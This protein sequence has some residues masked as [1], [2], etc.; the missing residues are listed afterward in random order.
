MH[1]L[2][3]LG[4]ITVS[5]FKQG[6]E[7]GSKKDRKGDL[8]RDRKKLMLLN[9]GPG[10]GNPKHSRLPLPAPSTLRGQAGQCAQEEG[11]LAK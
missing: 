3:G 4:G 7:K 8:K 11:T 5:N 10:P 1:E 6:T 9:R 2:H